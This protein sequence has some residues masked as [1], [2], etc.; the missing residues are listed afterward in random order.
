[1]VDRMRR[2]EIIKELRKTIGGDDCILFAYLHGSLAE[3][4]DHYRDIDV[5]L[6]FRGKVDP[7]AGSTR[8][9]SWPPY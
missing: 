2:S 8:R 5:E 6:C 9:W 7:A 4:R 3:G 1:M